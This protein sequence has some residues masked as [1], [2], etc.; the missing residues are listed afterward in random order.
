MARNS[1]PVA[2]GII[3]NNNLLRR[4]SW[5]PRA[6]KLTSSIML[7]ILSFQASTRIDSF[8]ARYILAV[9]NWNMRVFQGQEEMQPLVV[10]LTVGS[11]AYLGFCNPYGVSIAQTPG[12]PIQ[13]VSV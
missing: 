9:S 13:S 3:F 11:G 5:R 6:L 7:D 2:A 10:L 8:Q 4:N 1:P 12:V